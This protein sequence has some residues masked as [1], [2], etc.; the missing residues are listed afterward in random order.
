MSLSSERG[1]R[2]EDIARIY[3]EDCG[4][5]CLARRYRLPGG[6]IDLVM[7]GPDLLV[8]VEVKVAGPGTQAGPICRVDGRKMALLRAMARRYMDREG[9]PQG[10]WLRFDVVGISLLGPGRGLVLDHHAGVG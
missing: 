10:V 1:Q 6:E 7:R 3:L 5:Q 2:G 8:F 4:F 9:R